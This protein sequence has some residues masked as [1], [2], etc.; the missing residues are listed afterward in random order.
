MSDDYKCLSFVSVFT[1]RIVF[2]DRIFLP[3]RFSKNHAPMDPKRIDWPVFLAAIDS[4]QDESSKYSHVKFYFIGFNTI[5][6]YFY[7]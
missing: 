1:K 5:M 3:H 4:P 2:Q 7:C 6:L